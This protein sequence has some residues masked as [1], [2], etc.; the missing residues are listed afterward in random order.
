M[1]RRLRRGTVG[2]PRRCRIRTRGDCGSEP[3]AQRRPGGFVDTVRHRRR[4][5]SP[6]SRGGGELPAC[7]RSHRADHRPVAR[8]RPR[9]G[10]GTGSRRGDHRIHERP[11][12]GIGTFDSRSDADHAC[13]CRPTSRRRRTPRLAA[14]SW[15]RPPTTPSSRAGS[16][17]RD[18]ADSTWWM[19]ER[20][21]V[22]RRAPG[23][24]PAAH[25]SAVEPPSAGARHR[26]LARRRCV[27]DC[28]GRRIRTGLQ[29]VGFLER[30]GRGRHRRPRRRPRDAT[31]VVEHLAGGSGSGRRTRL[32]D[33]G[34]VLP[35]HAVVR[36][37]HR[38]APGSC[39]NSR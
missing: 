9:H 22:T 13:W 35:R 15:P 14:S 36:A 28:R 20:R 11:G 18:T 31:A 5:R 27:L 26:G 21:A 12:L 1:H 34:A 30:P 29:R 17:W 6:W 38:N 19:H 16:R 32:G 23:R 37:P 2:P 3:R 7:P 25:R 33:R 24:H 10:R 39:S 8:G 4:H